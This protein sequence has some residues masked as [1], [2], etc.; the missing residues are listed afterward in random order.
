MRLIQRRGNKQARIFILVFSLVGIELLA[1]HNFARKRSLRFV[2]AKHAHLNFTSVKP[3]LNHH[4]AVVA[5]RQIQT[6]K[7]FLPVVRLS[8]ANRRAKIGGLY[9]Q[10]VRRNLLALF[11]R[12]LS[13]GQNFAAAKHH[14]RRGRNAMR[15]HHI[16]ENAFIHA[17]SRADHASAHICQ[18]GQL[19]QAL[20]S[21]VLAKSAVQHRE[22]HIHMG[23]GAN[24]TGFHFPK[25]RLAG[26]GQKRDRRKPG[27]TAAPKGVQRPLAGP[28]RAILGNTDGVNAVARAVKRAE[29]RLR[30][31]Q[32]NLMLARA[33]AKEHNHIHFLTHLASS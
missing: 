3:L 24:S 13:I 16:F 15:A 22:N 30:R 4:A 6:G 12:R 8:Y 14:I 29:H 7:Q 9:K 19:Q 18:I 10:G 25:V 33:T 23:I 20:Q 21:A 17:H 5:R 27:N 1:R 2:V 32:R 28:P 26:D 11:G 31:H